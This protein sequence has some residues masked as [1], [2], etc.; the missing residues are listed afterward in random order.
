MS[1]KL[2]VSSPTT[3]E[4]P[5]SSDDEDAAAKAL[6]FRVHT[7][8]QRSTED[9]SRLQ[10]VVD[11]P[12]AW[13]P[14][15]IPLSSVIQSTP[16]VGLPVQRIDIEGARDCF[17]LQNVLSAA[18]CSRLVDAGEAQ[19]FEY[20]G[21]EADVDGDING[22]ANKNIS[23]KVNNSYRSAHTLEMEHPDL[24]DLIW[25]RVKDAVVQEVHF[26]A[27]DDRCERDL[28][29][30][31]RACGV[32]STLLF[33]R[34]TGGENFGPHT[35]GCVIRDFNCRSLWPMVI[36]LNAPQGGGQTTIITDEQ[37]EH[38]LLRDESGRFTADPRFVVY[39]CVPEV[40]S[41][42]L[43][44]HTQMHEGR[45]VADNSV[46]YIIRTDI[47]D[48]SRSLL[49]AADDNAANLSLHCDPLEPLFTAPAD[50]EAFALWQ[51]AQLL[52]EKGKTDAAAFLFRRM[53]KISPSLAHFYGL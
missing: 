2:P 15:I 43:F 50:K 42:L 31:W 17:K 27:K 5:Q 9:D 51:E 1:P 23:P 7:R 36:Y 34:Y 28:Q 30:S 48:L 18:E 39:D 35:D 29:G 16:S 45:P 53:T 13:G 37:K 20:W 47:I 44:Y 52:A 24:A 3:E 26:S 40:G 19:G 8:K 25:K 38:P 33:A 11:K 49:C 12:V 4:D 32:N 46:K 6:R 10:H 41:S 21:K 14:S 22:R